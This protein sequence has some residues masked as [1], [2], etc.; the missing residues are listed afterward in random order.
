M[1][2]DQEMIKPG[3]FVLSLESDQPIIFCSQFGLQ[4]L[5]QQAMVHKTGTWQALKPSEGSL[6]C[7]SGSLRSVFLEFIKDGGHRKIVDFDEHLDDAS[8]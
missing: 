1:L 7:A 6:V 8:R 3:S 5:V 2:V 4:I